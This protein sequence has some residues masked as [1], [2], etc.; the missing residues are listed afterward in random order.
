MKFIIFSLF[1]L[2]LSSSITS[3]RTKAKAI[4]NKEGMMTYLNSF[5]SDMGTLPKKEE[6]HRFS[7]VP[8]RREDNTTIAQNKTLEGWFMIQSSIYTNKINFPELSISQNEKYKIPL[9]FDNWR[10]NTDVK[11]K[12]ENDNKF[13]ID[14]KKRDFVNF[15]GW[16]RAE[17]G[18]SP[19]RLSSLRAVLS[20]F[21][22][23]IRTSSK[24]YFQS[25]S[26]IINTKIKCKF[27]SNFSKK[28]DSY[29]FLRS[30]RKTCFYFWTDTE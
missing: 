25:W 4:A 1:L 14:V 8:D 23:F 3:L 19:N 30:K 9:D 2:Y 10:I 7:Q 18:W 26:K 24:I 29:F 21:S 13:F 15:F 20:S 12:N 6:P 17:M 11:S 27:E 22:N 5:F 16:G 28:S